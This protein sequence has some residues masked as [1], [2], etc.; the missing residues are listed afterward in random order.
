MNDRKEINLFI[1][2]TKYVKYTSVNW[3]CE[4]DAALLSLC[5]VLC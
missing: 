4:T 1:L 5:D 3:Y 2:N